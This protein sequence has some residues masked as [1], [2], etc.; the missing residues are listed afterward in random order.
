MEMGVGEPVPFLQR[1]KGLY[2][3]YFLTPN[4]LVGLCFILS[5]RRIK[6]LTVTLNALILSLFPL[7]WFD[8]VSLQVAYFHFSQRAS[9]REYHNSSWETNIFS[10]IY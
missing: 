2:F 1:D 3:E 5:Y 7:G 4:N 8:A 6:F 10:V 9:H